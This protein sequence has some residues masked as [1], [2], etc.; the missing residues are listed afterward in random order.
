MLYAIF[1]VFANSIYP[2]INILKKIC[3]LFSII[4]LPNTLSLAVLNVRQQQFLQAILSIK[5]VEFIKLN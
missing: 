3:A 4:A 1:E 5:E 2:Q